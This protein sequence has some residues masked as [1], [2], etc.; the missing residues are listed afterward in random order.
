M[1]CYAIC[2]KCSVQTLTRKSNSESQAIHNELEDDRNDRPHLTTILEDRQIRQAPRRLLFLFFPFWI[3]TWHFCSYAISLL[4][5]QTNIGPRFPP[6]HED[7][8]EFDKNHEDCNSLFPLLLDQWPPY[9]APLLLK[10]DLT[11]HLTSTCVLNLESSA[12]VGDN[13]TITFFFFLSSLRILSVDLIFRYLILILLR[14]HQHA[15][16]MCWTC[17]CLTFIAK[18]LTCSYHAFYMQLPCILHAVAMPYFTY[19]PSY[20]VVLS[21]AS[22]YLLNLNLFLLEFLARP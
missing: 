21:L 20:L 17:I 2:P 6:Y 9:P 15:T 4:G 3:A 1:I 10:H 18:H 5:F 13:V 8:Q 7:C 22:Y 12:I 14:S 11:S 19:I 16:T